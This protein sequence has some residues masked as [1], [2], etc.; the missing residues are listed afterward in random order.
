MA[1]AK[2]LQPQ[3]QPPPKELILPIDEM[4]VDNK[5]WT[6]L[7]LSEP[8]MKTISEAV[9]LMDNVDGVPTAVSAQKFL[10]KLIS[11][12]TGLPCEEVEKL[13]VSTVN[14]GG[15][16]LADFTNIGI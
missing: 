8:S 15:K 5:K 3:S 12:H 10:I 7:R 6:E 14:K 16:Y 2:P 9:A 11:G 13:K 4:I 1:T